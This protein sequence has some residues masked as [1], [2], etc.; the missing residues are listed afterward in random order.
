MPRSEQAN[1]QIREERR[2]Q[3]LLSAAQ[4][5]ARK[6]LADTKIADIAAAAG[7]SHGLAYR[8]F[9]SKDD[10]FA[11]LVER[12]MNGAARLA[13]EALEQP[14]T[15]WDRLLWLTREI[16]P[17]TAPSVQ[18]PEYTLVVLQA[19]T[20]EAVPAG[21]RE[22]ALEQSLIMN[23]VVRRLIA[24]GQRTGQVIA[25]DPATL[26]L[27]YLS[28]IQGLSLTVRF[29]GDPVPSFPTADAVLRILKA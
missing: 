18:Q 29:L 3:I 15:P 7:V 20:N 4:V 27:L 16:F 11:A 28:C 2:E 9:A 6:G 25:G 26:A 14:G 8:Y 1:Q 22:L 17:V 21:V 13:R 10:V 23:D 24:D 5:F 19:L 12:A